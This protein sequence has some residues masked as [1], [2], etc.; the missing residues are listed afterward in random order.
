MFTTMVFIQIFTFIQYSYHVYWRSL[1][2][3]PDAIFESLKNMIRKVLAPL[4]EFSNIV[5]R[6]AK[7]HDFCHEKNLL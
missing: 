3:K 2:R 7:T 1:L 4:V 5:I 6:K